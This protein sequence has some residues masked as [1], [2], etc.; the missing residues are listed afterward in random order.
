MHFNVGLMC[1]VPVSTAH[2][3]EQLDVNETGTTSIN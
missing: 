2:I 3:Y 1:S